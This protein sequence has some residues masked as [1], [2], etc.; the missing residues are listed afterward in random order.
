MEVGVIEGTN[1]RV[2]LSI[3]LKPEYQE[4]WMSVPR[5]L[6]IIVARRMIGW[7]DPDFLR[8]MGFVF[9]YTVL[10]MRWRHGASVLAM[11]T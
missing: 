1:F 8:K 11:E 3:Y 4:G 10:L 7:R 9:R 6:R 2:R 5:V